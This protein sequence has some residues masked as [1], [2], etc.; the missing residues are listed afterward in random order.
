MNDSSFFSENTLLLLRFIL[1]HLYFPSRI[2]ITSS[3]LFLALF[4]TF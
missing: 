1:Q 4:K 3:D 2:S